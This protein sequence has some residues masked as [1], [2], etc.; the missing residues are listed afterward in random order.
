MKT[1][2]V[3]KIKVEIKKAKCV[4]LIPGWDNRDRHVLL[5]WLSVLVVVLRL[6]A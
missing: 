5:N 4:H 1:F 3:W 6:D 2:R